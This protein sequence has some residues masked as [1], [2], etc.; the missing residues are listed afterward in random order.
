MSS[1]L[2]TQNQTAIFEYIVWVLGAIMN[3]IFNLLYAI[4][5]PNIGLSIILFTIVMYM[6][7]TPLTMKQQKFSKLSAKM[8]PELQS[9]KAKYNGKK[10]NESMMAMNQETQ[11]VYGKYGVSPT[12]S[13]L[14]LLIQMPVL[15]ALYKVIYSMPAYVTKIKD[16]FTPLITK[17]TETDIPFFQDNISS[18]AFY[19][20]NFEN[21]D[22]FDLNNSFIDVLNRAST[23]DW[24]KLTTNFPKISSEISSTHDKLMQF[25]N[26]LG[27]NIADSPSLIVSAG[28]KSGAWLLVVGAIA[29]PLLSALTQFI[30]VKLM[31]QAAPS[32]N[33]T[34]PNAMASSM[35]TMNM[36]MPIMSAFFCYTLPAG[37]GIYWIAG[38]VV[39]TVQQIVINKHIDGM[40]LDELIKTNV[41]KNNKKRKKKGLPPQQINMNAKTSTKNVNNSVKKIE[42]SQE[43][44][45]DLIKSSTEYYK[46]NA[47]PGSL[48]SKAN[49][50]KQ[51]NEKNNK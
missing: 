28:I 25:N 9:I 16:V 27:L 7:M 44:K 14:Q 15:F 6:L 33:G 13:C 4:G 21:L 37:M 40:D 8:N 36:I 17:F 49:M 24:E 39:R 23:S 22:K 30:S 20:K 12:G 50:V 38:A 32:T 3:G 47:K 48:A 51:Y 2:L 1:I 11:A 35:K 18:F 10:D 5:I 34:E 41:E 26:F 31:P 43:Q 46:S 45:N 42:K 29:I 19:K